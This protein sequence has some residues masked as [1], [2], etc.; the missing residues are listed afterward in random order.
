[1][2]SAGLIVAGYDKYKGGDVYSIPLGGSVHRQE[3]AIGGSG[4]SYIY[5]FCDKNFTPN[6]SKEEGIEFLRQIISLAMKRDGSSGGVIRMAVIT[7]EGVE[8]LFF[9]EENHTIPNL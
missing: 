9:S 5:G 1:M 6:M 3:I 7:E 4:S 2:L 8:R